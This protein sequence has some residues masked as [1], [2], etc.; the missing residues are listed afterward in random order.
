MTD[1]EAAS[2]IEHVTEVLRANGFR[3]THQRLEVVREL[4]ATDAHPD[5]E[6]VFRSD[7]KR[8]PTIS[9]D[10]VYRTLGTLADLGLVSRFV[11]ASGAVRYDP[12]L[13]QH[14]H[15]VCTGCVRIY[16]VENPD[17]DHVT[18][19]DALDKIGQVEQV[20]VRFRGVCHECAE[21]LR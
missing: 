13:A 21:Q 1:A 17:L 15:F 18:A 10:T 3:L 20:E 8:V 6:H 12:N 19:P 11:G 2:G 5:A 4:A 9:L 16:D 14:R 7:R